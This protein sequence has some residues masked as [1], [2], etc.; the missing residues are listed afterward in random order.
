MSLLRDSRPPPVIHSGSPGCPLCIIH[1]PPCP[2]K[3][4]APQVILKGFWEMTAIPIY[5]SI[6]IRKFL[7]W[8][9]FV[10]V[11]HLLVRK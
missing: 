4:M 2:E 9:Y 11:R 5:R 8:L 10:T 1:P 7:L 6:S 3:L